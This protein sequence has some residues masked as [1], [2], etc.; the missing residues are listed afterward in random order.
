MD[1]ADSAALASFVALI[2]HRFG[3]IDVCVTNSEAPPSKVYMST[4]PEAWRAAAGQLL[5]STI[6]SVKKT[7]P[8][9]Q[10]RDWGGLT[11]LISPAI[12]PPVDDGLVRSLL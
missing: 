3:R 9:I 7:S 1:I 6:H 12:N 11:T 5:R 4:A 10:K 2:E 8:R